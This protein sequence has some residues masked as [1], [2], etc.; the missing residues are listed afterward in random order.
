METTIIKVSGMS[1]GG[2]VKSVTQVLT[3]QPGVASAAVSLERA[4]AQVGFDPLLTTR[5][6]LLAAIDAA[7]FEAT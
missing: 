3:G 7:G 4:E 5:A 2:C 1:C 6:A